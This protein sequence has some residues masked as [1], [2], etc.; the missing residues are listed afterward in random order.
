MN[1]M[2]TRGLGYTGGRIASYVR[3]KAP[4]SHIY[5]TTRDRLL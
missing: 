1:I 3:E 2:I 5:L 4:D